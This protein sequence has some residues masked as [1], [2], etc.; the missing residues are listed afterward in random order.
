M[1]TTKL[2]YDEAVFLLELVDEY[3]GNRLL[4]GL[5]KDTGAEET[6]TKLQQLISQTDQ[7][8]YPQ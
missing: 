8:E 5:D 7:D 6:S 4:N 1:I 2:D 3:R